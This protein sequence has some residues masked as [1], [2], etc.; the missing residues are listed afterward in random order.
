[1]LLFS[2][3]LTAVVNNVCLN[4]RMSNSYENKFRNGG[5]LDKYILLK[6]INNNYLAK[7]AEQISS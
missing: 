1:M 7:F 2:M 3:Y 5:I 4:G 6:I